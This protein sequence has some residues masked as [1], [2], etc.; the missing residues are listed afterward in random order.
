MTPAIVT[1]DT[2]T[3]TLT[4]APR[5]GE[6]EASLTRSV[7][8][9]YDVLDEDGCAYDTC[10][11]I[12]CSDLRTVN[13]ELIRH[14]RIPEGCT[15]HLFDN[16]DELFADMAVEDIDTERMDTSHVTSMVDM[17]A[18]CRNLKSAPDV[19]RWDT[20][21]VCD[22]SG[23]FYHCDNMATPPGTGAW[24]TG[25]VRNMHS[26]FSKCK[27]MATPPDTRGW[28]TSKLACTCAMFNRCESM[29]A[30]PDTSGWR[31]QALTD[32]SWMFY[33]CTS[34]TEAPQTAGWDMRGMCKS[35]HAFG[36]CTNLAVTPNMSRRTGPI[37]QPSDTPRRV[38]MTSY[39]SDETEYDG[40]S[41]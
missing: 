18:R 24:D 17:F 8:F 38:I 30:P 1:Y 3:R 33:G 41:Y 4:I 34:L 35:D 22:M 10:S 40:P 21:A 25:S 36:G 29:A 7:R 12:A 39:D 23:M 15:I 16:M 27:A 37:Q 11:R 20:H 14:V 26:M 19:G 2:G 6:T 28:D 32:T 5:E 9:T 31:T 13:P